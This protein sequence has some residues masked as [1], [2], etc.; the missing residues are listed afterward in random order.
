[1]KKE[2]TKLLIESKIN[3]FSKN[4][5]WIWI[6]AKNEKGYGVI[7]IDGKRHRAHRLVYEL[8]VGSIPPGMLVCHSCDEPSCCNPK[9]LWLGT[10][11]DNQRDKHAKGR[12]RGWMVSDENRA[13]ISELHKGNTYNLG[14][15]LSDD[16][17]AK[18][19]ASHTGKT[20]SNEH[21][22][23]I[24]AS[25]IGREVSS[26]TREILRAKSTGNKN[27]LGRCHSDDAKAARS[28][29]M[30]DNTRGKG[31]VRTAES[32]ERYR[33]AAIKREAVRKANKSVDAVN[34]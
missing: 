5:C 19:S 25:L 30:I 6:G 32:K 21:K 26:E 18:L 1:M 22:A 11:A 7:Q 33:Q 24:G 23:K 9:H 31:S 28:K 2:K 16:H 3:R 13:R 34:D 4:S 8:Y 17:K 27:A 10:N 14:R 29:T 12:G 15:V 20:L